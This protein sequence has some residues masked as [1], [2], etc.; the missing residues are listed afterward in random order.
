MSEMVKLSSLVDLAVAQGARGAE[1]IGVQGSGFTLKPGKNGTRHKETSRDE[2]VVRVWVDAGRSG[3]KVGRLAD[4]EDLVGQALAST[5]ESA[6]DAHGG[7]VEKVGSIPTGLGVL[8]RR[9]ANLELSDRIEALEDVLRQASQDERFEA[10]DFSYEDE[11]TWR[12]V[13]NSRGVHFEEHA[14]E[15]HLTGAIQGQGL[16]LEEHQASRAFAS[17]ASLPL[18]TRLLQRANALLVDG[19]VLEPGPVRVVLPPRP[20]ARLIA[21]LGEHFTPGELSDNSF[22]F[23]DQGAT[24]SV[25]T[26]LHIVDDGLLPGGLRT[27]AFDDRGCFP[28]PVML[29]REGVVAGRYLTPEL[30]RKLDTRAT[31]HVYRSGLRSNNLVM[32]EGTRSI[33]AML[34]ER[35]GPSLVIDDLPNLKKLNLKTG[36]IE[37]KVDGIVMDANK[38]VGAMRGVTLRGNLVTLL[39]NVV[40]LCNNTDRIGHVDAAS[41]IADGLEL[42]G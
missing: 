18:G 26:A 27:R 6:E 14:S 13:A 5:Y 35:K 32:R 2:L 22:L 31:G 39:S 17:I 4:G 12:G 23:Q 25:S 9:H 28:V 1:V 29:L 33:N 20:M 24:A 30:A 3:V 16:R 10:V 7:P 41:I 42:V 21:M 11:R 37:V 36:A 38:P 40:C 15:F 34:T 8:D 19:A